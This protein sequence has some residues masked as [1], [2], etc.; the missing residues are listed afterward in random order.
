[1]LSGT[2]Q[3][4]AAANQP[5]TRAHGRSMAHAAD[6]S[7]ALRSLVKY[8]GALLTASDHKVAGDFGVPAFSQGR[9]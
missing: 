5:L 8:L 7:A 1:M 9:S 6:I 3:R 4:I 2:G